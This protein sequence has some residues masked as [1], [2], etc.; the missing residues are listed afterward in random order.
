MEH[1]ILTIFIVLLVLIALFWFLLKLRTLREDSIQDEMPP[2]KLTV[3]LGMFY[4]LSRA[5]LNYYRDRNTYP[6]AVSGTPDGL[7]ELGYLNDEP[8]AQLSKSVK[9]FSIVVTDKG[10]YGICLAHIK[11]SVAMEFL[12]RV[13]ETKTTI[14]FQDYR[15]GQYKPLTSTGDTLINLTLPLPVRPIGAKPP[16][17]VDAVAT[18]GATA[19]PVSGEDDEE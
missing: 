2:D 9:L 8:L 6:P 19:V 18:P 7:M 11:A 14:E 16:S 12:R 15:G 3:L 4:V 10:G 17:P 13:S 1:P 5:C